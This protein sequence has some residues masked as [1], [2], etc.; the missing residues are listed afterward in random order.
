M[1]RC[2]SIAQRRS[3]ISLVWATPGR[4]WPVNSLLAIP[5]PPPTCFS[6]GFQPGG[7]R[8]RLFGGNIASL[9]LSGL[10]AIGGSLSLTSQ[11]YTF[12]TTKLNLADVTSFSA[13]ASAIRNALDA[14]VPV[15]A[16]TTGSS[17][18]R[19]SVPFTGSLDKNALTVTNVSS[20]SIQIGSH[21]FG[22]GVRSGIQIVAQL[23]GTANGTG[24]YAVQNNP[25]APLESMTDLYGV[26]TVGSVGGSGTVAVGQDVTGASVVSDTA[27]QANLSGSGAGS[28][29]VVN[30]AE[31]VASEAMTTTAAPLNVTY[32][33]VT[34][35]TA[36]SKSFWIEQG[37]RNNALTSSIMTYA[38]GTAA[39]RLG[40]TQAKGAYDS[41]PGQVVTSA[42]AWMNNITHTQSAAFSSFQFVDSPAAVT[43]TDL[44]EWAQSTAGVHTYLGAAGETPPAVDQYALNRLFLDSSDRTPLGE[45][46]PF[47]SAA[48]VANYY[49]ATSHEAHLANEFFK[50]YTGSSATMLFAFLSPTGDFS[51]SDWMDNFVDTEADEFSSFQTTYSPKSATPPGLQAGMEAWAQ[52]TGGQYDYLACYSANTPP[53]D[54]SPRADQLFAEAPTVGVPEPSTWATVLLGFA[55]L[56]LARYWPRLST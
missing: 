53:I 19:V 43:N 35:A 46:L 11:G 5:A 6:P 3:R 49:G 27:I 39:A 17:I 42:S 16:V 10:Q 45:V 44:Q 55:G 18:A 2:R 47:T 30:T 25:G 50:G 7:G 32:H 12:S 22:S 14:N 38:G 1:R 52:S 31:T 56:S 4:P 41:T 51:A 20:G 34:G 26:L 13:A 37:A 15:S 8:A 36:N 9:T 48:A 21:L 33:A 29:W 40:L 23:S 54:G 24:T 28:T